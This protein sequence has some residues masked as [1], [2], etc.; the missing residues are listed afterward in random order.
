MSAGSFLRQVRRFVASCL[1]LRWRELDRG[2]RSDRLSA[3]WMAMERSSLIYGVGDIF[4]NFG[5]WKLARGLIEFQEN[6]G[7]L[8]FSEIKNKKRSN[9]VAV[10]V[11]ETEVNDDGLRESTESICCSLEQT[12][13]LLPT[14]AV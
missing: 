4:A 13:Q 8:F 2:M 9:K 12:S 5:V 6:K 3:R 7:K 14:E 11:K 10:C 1:Q